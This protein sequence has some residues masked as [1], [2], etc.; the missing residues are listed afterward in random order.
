MLCGIPTQH[1]ISLLLKQSSRGQLGGFVPDRI[2]SMS[3]QA[4][5]PRMNL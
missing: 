3:Q 5:S 4:L 1:L 2:H